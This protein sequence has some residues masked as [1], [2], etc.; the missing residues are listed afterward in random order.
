[1]AQATHA[2]LLPVKWRG[3]RRAKA[4]HVNRHMI[5]AASKDDKLPGCVMRAREDYERLYAPAGGELE[6]ELWR[7]MKMLRSLAREPGEEW[8]RHMAFIVHV[9]RVPGE[10][11]A[12]HERNADAQEESQDE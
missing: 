1:V 7:M 9:A 3:L 2:S 10:Q 12:F 5:D 4:Y 8:R 6:G 11:V